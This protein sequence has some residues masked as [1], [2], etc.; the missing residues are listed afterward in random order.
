MLASIPRARARAGDF[1]PLDVQLRGQAIAI[2][3]RTQQG[4]D[5]DAP[6]EIVDW[7][8]AE[9]EAFMARAWPPHNTPLGIE[10]VPQAVVLVARASG[11]IG[12]ARGVI[13]GGVGELKELLVEREHAKRSVG[14]RLLAEFE[15]RCR[16]AGCHKL[17]ARDGRLPGAPLLRAPRLQRGDNADERSLRARLVRD[18]QTP[19]M[20][21]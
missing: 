6:I 8:N 12:V 16:A 7:T 1:A 14:S 13:V 19:L 9:V 17:R 3:A 4:S 10:W 20:F 5:M 15:S 11:P 2:A 21:R 18:A